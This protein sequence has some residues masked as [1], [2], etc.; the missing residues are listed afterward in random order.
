MSH[1]AMYPQ[2]DFTS[3]SWIE[4]Q[5]T[6]WYLYIG[7][8][9]L[10][11]A[12]MSF[13]ARGGKKPTTTAGRRGFD[14]IPYFRKWKLQADKIPTPQEQWNCTRQVLFWHFTVELPV[15]WLFH[16]VAETL[17]MRKHEV[18]LPGFTEWAPQ[19]AFF[20]VFEDT[21]HYFAHRA[22]HCDSLYEHI[23]R[24]HHMY[25]AP[26]GLAAQYAHPAE[27]AILG[28]GTIAGP[29][30]WCTLT[31]N[32]HIFSVYI[33]I[34]L[35][36]F[37]AIDAHSGYELPGPCNTGCRSGLARSTTTSTIWCSRTTSARLSGGGIACLAQTTGIGRTGL[38]RSQPRTNNLVEVHLK[39]KS[40]AH[41]LKEGGWARGV[42]LV[43]SLDF[44]L[45]WSCLRQ[46]QQIRDL[47]WVQIL[48]TQ[49][50]PAFHGGC[51]CCIPV[52]KM[53]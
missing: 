9:I 41:N 26:F 39:L 11:T 14:A 36:L 42:T 21:F 51:A 44:G 8:P 28:T 12:L 6:A 31:G 23:H 25:S 40:R 17:G 10:A 33:W 27:V 48:T 29:I 52:R 47:N 46:S 1:N 22:L 32:L 35:R 49:E 20:F 37:Q 34:T 16:P 3:L 13:S 5:W 30:L 15:I 50:R 45:F 53:E 38:P 43:E 24:V 18:P 19:V 2:V 7:N 4:E